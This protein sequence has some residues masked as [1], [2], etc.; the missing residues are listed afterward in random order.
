MIRN[1]LMPVTA[2]AAVLAMGLALSAP[3]ARAEMVS[4]EQALSEMSIG[5]KDAP[6]T[7]YAY[8]SLA[9]PAC[10]AFHKGAYG[11]LKKQYVETGKVRIVFRDFPTNGRA[12]FAAKMARCLGPE[13]YV[14][15]I[16]ALFKNQERWAFVPGNQFLA[17]LG[18][19]AR[20]G[21]MTDAEF[22]KCMEDRE[23]HTAFYKKVQGWQTTY[24]IR[25]TPTFII[26]DKR[27][28]GVQSIEAFKEILDPM[29]E[30]AAK[31]KSN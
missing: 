30:A 15:M 29:I 12:F 8:E 20:L 14:P 1:I 11:E 4:T 26:G 27:L 31:K 18:N 3:A 19:Y 9:C 25:S 22:K 5:K 21:G 16:E 13:K 28:E 6:V 24:G 2:L 17:T 7:I 10:A 23:F